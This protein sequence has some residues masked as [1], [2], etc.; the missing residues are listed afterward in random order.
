MPPD[1]EILEMLAR[2]VLGWKAEPVRYGTRYS[3]FPEVRTPLFIYIDDSPYIEKHDGWNPLEKIEDA[4]VLVEKLRL[5]LTP[6]ANCWLCAHCNWWQ[7]GETTAVGMT[8]H[9]QW[10]EAATAPRAIC[11]TALTE[12]AIRLRL[13]GKK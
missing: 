13:K 10:V 7:S 3:G 2:D 11:L 12:A 5:T 8:N 6:G 4:W 1:R 9:Q